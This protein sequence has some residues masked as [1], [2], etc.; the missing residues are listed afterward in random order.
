MRKNVEEN[1]NVDAVH[2]QIINE[3]SG[4]PYS[5]PKKSWTVPVYYI[6]RLLRYDLGTDA[7]YP[8][9]TQGMLVGH[10]Q[11]TET[12]AILAEI[13]LDYPELKGYN[14]IRRIL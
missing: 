10:P 12:V 3:K 13:E 14:D 8:I 4:F 7:S 2:E 11:E 5:S 9:I 1:L 6:W